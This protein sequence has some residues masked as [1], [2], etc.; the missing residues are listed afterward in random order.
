MNKLHDLY[1]NRGY[2]GI[3]GTDFGIAIIIILI[4]L[5]ITSYS[6][7]TS[8]LL[9]LQT[10]WDTN[11]CNPIIM[12]FAGIIMPQPGI[13]TAETTMTNFSYCIKQDVSMIFSIALMPLEFSIYV[14]IEFI[15]ASIDTLNAFLNFTQWLKEQLGEYT[16]DIYNQIA[17]VIISIIE[18]VIYV[19]DSMAKI[20]GIMVTSLFI[21]MTVYNSTVSGIIN[22]MNIL[23]DLLLIFI[24]VL[25]VLLVI[26]FALFMTPAFPVGVTIYASVTATLVI[27][28]VPI[29]VMYVLMQTFTDAVTNEPSAEPAEEPDVKKKPKPKINIF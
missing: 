24:A 21:V 16:V 8:L 18:I 22:T 9:Q 11:K 25:V 27:L 7:Y 3:Y 1:K 6:S 15:D 29:L 19:R 12:P 20:N 14:V 2:W 4:T 13:S 5:G 26:A 10:N 23:T 17:S 28:I